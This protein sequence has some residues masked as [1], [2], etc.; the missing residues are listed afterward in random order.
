[1][2]RA[3][4]L[5]AL[6]KGKL[7]LE[8]AKLNHPQLEAEILL[9][10]LTGYKRHELYLKDDLVL[11]DDFYDAFMDMIEK[12]SENMPIQYITGVESFMGM[13]F[14]VNR[15]TLIPRPDTEVLVESVVKFMRRTQGSLKVLD[16]CTGSGNIAVSLAKIVPNAKIWAVDVSF[17]A[18][19]VARENARL[20]DVE[21]RVNFLVGDMFSPLEDCLR[22]DVIVSNPPY[23]K[24]DDISTLEPQVKLYEPHIALDGGIDGLRFFRE[25]IERSPSFLKSGGLLACEV[26]HDQAESIKEILKL[27]GNYTEIETVKDLAMIDRVV[28]ANI[29]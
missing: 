21:Y 5:A 27:N 14:K 1:M 19:E 2:D 13:D 18:I 12:R 24:S 3:L 9:A 7:E 26:G 10:R 8:R 4:L 23:I 6:S 22:F 17:E 28:L 25:L 15:H 16:M 29:I 20:N 11:R